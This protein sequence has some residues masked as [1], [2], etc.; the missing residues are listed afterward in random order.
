MKVCESSPSR[1][2]KSP[3]S[4][5]S[6]YMAEPYISIFRLCPPYRI[7]TTPYGS[8]YHI[9]P[10]LPLNFSFFFSDSPI[11]KTY[12]FCIY[13]PILVEVKRLNK[14]KG[15]TVWQAYKID[16][17][18][19]LHSLQ[20]LTLLTRIYTIDKSLHPLQNFTFCTR[21]SILNKRFHPLQDLH[22]IQALPKD[23]ACHT[24]KPLL[25]KSPGTWPSR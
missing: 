9:I 10:A 25:K 17:A 4:Q 23:I 5:P 8:L 16:A 14:K 21:V 20:E 12:A 15:R 11:Q 18:K 6:L 2:Q 22:P 3:G 19:S 13:E 24:R 7:L 1:D